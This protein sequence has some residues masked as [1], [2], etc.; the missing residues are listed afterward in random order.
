MLRP[1]QALTLTGLLLLLLL[2]GC[3]DGSDNERRTVEEDVQAQEPCN[4]PEEDI[5]VNATATNI[6]FVR[7]PDAC[8]DNLDGYP[9]TP[10]Y[11]EVEGL[12]YH[13]VDEGPY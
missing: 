12:R 8:F 7:T 6:E 2:A 4:I 3:H 9:F 1:K 13:F 11:V 10:N 5:Q